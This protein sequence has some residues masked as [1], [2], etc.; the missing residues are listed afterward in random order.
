MQVNMFEAKTELSRLVKALETKQED[1][2]YL[3]RN[4]RP[5]VQMTRI[6]D[7]KTSRRIG[8]AEG[9]FTCPDTLGESTGSG[10]PADRE[11]RGEA[12]E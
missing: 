7:R 1:V 8:V 2:V 9:R 3:A 11:K 4:G 5:V 12:R 10:N 6:P